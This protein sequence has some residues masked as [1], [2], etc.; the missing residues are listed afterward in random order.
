M[1]RFDFYTAIYKS[2]DG[3]IPNDIAGV[4]TYGGDD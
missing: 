3:N 4:M 1:V 2:I